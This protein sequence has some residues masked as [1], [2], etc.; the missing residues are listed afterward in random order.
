MI[1]T[2][3]VIIG[4][5]AGGPARYLTDRWMQHK[6]APNHPSRI[7]W[8]I[9]SVNLIGSLLL[10]IADATLSSVALLLAGTGFCGAFTTFSTFAALSE[11][12]WD[13]G[14][15]GV[16]VGNVVVSVVLCVGAFWVGA[17]VIGQAIAGG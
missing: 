1:E 16:S 3:A 9:L 14:W 13:A 7:A 5:A 2:L 15:R 17:M 6:I 8:G 12:S 11:E 4:A 10:G